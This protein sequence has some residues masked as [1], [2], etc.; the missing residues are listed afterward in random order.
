ML[1]FVVTLR[2]LP[3]SQ[4]VVCAPKNLGAIGLHEPVE[5]AQRD[6]H[7]PSLPVSTVTVRH[8]PSILLDQTA[9][10]GMIVLFINWARANLRQR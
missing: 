2:A 5:I 6:D 10:V 4:R 9:A 7:R 8:M 3:A 1:M